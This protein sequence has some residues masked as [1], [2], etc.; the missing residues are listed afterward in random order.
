M[1]MKHAFLLTL[2]LFLLGVVGFSS[3]ASA[4][5]GAGGQ[6]SVKGQITFYEGSTESST[7]ESSTTEPTTSTSSSEVP[8]ESSD[9][10]SEVPINS[11][12]TTKPQGQGTYP[13]TGETIRNYSFVGAGA[14]LLFVLILLNRRKKKEEEA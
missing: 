1:K 9:S 8:L 11:G 5:T 7:V 4:T 2:G 12:T 10:S 13:S 3:L 6:V 14:I